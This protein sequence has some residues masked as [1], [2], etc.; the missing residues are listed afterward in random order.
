MID[1]LS[2]VLIGIASFL[3]LGTV[4]FL[5]VIGIWERLDDWRIDRSARRTA[6]RRGA[7]RYVRTTRH[8][9]SVSESADSSWSRER[10]RQ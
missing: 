7:N 10:Q 5:V 4:V 3:S 2:Y 1:V 9:G 6:S 8:A